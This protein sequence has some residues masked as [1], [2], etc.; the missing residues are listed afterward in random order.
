MENNKGKI[1]PLLKQPDS[2]RPDTFELSKNIK[3][4]E[5]WLPTLERMVKKNISK[6]KVLNPDCPK[7]AEKAEL[8][9]KKFHK[10]VEELM[11]DPT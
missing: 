9:Y 1:C 6:A 10:L 2:Y 3:E 4:R 11:E 7:A 5:Y 8:C